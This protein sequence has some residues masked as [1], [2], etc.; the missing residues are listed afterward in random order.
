MKGKC[1]IVLDGSCVKVDKQDMTFAG[2]NCLVSEHEGV[3]NVRSS[4]FL[5]QVLKKKHVIS[6][7]EVFL[8][9]IGC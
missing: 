1:A 7:Q 3:R 2:K 6:N 4:H 5:N 9:W 8:M